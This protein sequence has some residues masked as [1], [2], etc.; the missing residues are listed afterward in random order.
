MITTPEPPPAAPVAPPRPSGESADK[1]DFRAV[2][3]RSW[4]VKVACGLIYDFSEL[5]TLRRYLAD[6]K[7]AM[8]DYIGTDRANWTKLKLSCV[9]R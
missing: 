9:G 2:G 3:I 8:D 5:S 6:G 1:L 4:K 7:V